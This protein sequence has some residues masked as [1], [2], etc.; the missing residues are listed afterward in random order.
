MVARD[1]GVGEKE[2]EKQ[3]GLEV[4]RMVGWGNKLMLTR[5]LALAGTRSLSPSSI[6]LCNPIQ[7]YVGGRSC[8]RV[9]L[10]LPPSDSTVPTHAAA[11]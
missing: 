8:M 4:V 10:T 1:C 7:T 9:L 2:A 3:T 6:H 11:A 5:V